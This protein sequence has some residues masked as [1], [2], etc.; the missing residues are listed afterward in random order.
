[1]IIHSENDLLQLENKKQ[2]GWCHIRYCEI[3]WM[4]HSKDD[5]FTIFIHILFIG[6][7]TISSYCSFLITF[8]SM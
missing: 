2:Q 3:E 5:V 7:F 6:S 1:M 4:D 8:Y